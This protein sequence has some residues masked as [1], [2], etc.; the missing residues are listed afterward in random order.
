MFIASVFLLALCKIEDTDTWMHLSLGRLI[1]ELK[2]FP[3]HETLVYTSLDKP[4]SYSSWLFGLIYY[5]SYLA[6]GYYGVILLKAFTVSTAFYILLRDSLRPHRNYVVSVAVLTFV[7]FMARH[8]FVERP[9]T[10]MAVFLPFSIFSL[11]AF[12]YDNKKYIYVLPLIHMLWANSH[13]SV[14][15]MVVPF[16]AFLMGGIIQRYLS[17]KGI[18]SCAQYSSVSQL[19]VVLTIFAVSFA[20][21]LIS[22]YAISQYSFGSQFLA[23]S[24]FKQEI[25]ELRPPTWAMMKLPFIVTP[26][27]FLSFFFNRKRVSVFHLFLVAPF[28][29]LQFTAV[30]FVFLFGIVSGPVV[31]RNVS[32]FVAARP[33]GGLSQR[34]WIEVAA[35]ISVLAVCSLT[36]LNIGPFAARSK[37]FGFGVNYDMA[38]M[39]VPEK[40]LQYMDRRGIT[41]R[42]FNTFHYG[43]YINWR[44]FPKRTVFIDP[45]GYMEAEL[46]E[47]TGRA[48]GNP[49]VFGELANR[50][51]FESC[52]ISYPAVSKADVE[53]TGNQLL[54][55]NAG[56]A[57]VY[58]DDV[59]LVYLKKG[60]KYDSV[61]RQDEYRFVNPAGGTLGLKF[62]ITDPLMREG[63]IRELE[64]NIRETGSSK[65]YEY[66]GHIFGEMRRYDEAVALLKK[67]LDSR[68]ANRHSIYYE[69]A[70]AYYGLG[71][72]A[73]SIECCQKSLA[74]GEDANGL[75]LLSM[76]YIQRGDYARA[77]KHLERASALEPARQ[78][79]Y[80][81]LMDTYARLGRTDKLEK[82]RGAYEKARKQAQA[83]SHFNEGVNAYF[84]G[85]LEL[86]AAELEKA[87]EIDPNS[88]SAYSNLGYVFFD[89]GNYAEA[90]EC[91][92]KAL[93]LDRN[94]ANAHYGLALIYRNLGDNEEAKRHWQEYLRIEPSGYYTRRA[95][96]GLKGLK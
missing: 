9:D 86:A 6:G 62:V 7:V 59:S 71:R 27:V 14:V 29:V 2:G 45:R 58:W 37:A 51:G 33:W 43:G 83:E 61:V 72:T 32:S 64:R 96:E 73:E 35:T 87:I 93:A 16:L 17:E 26:I 20:A 47:K 75:Y 48:P 80:P 68:Y 24:W 95:E 21:T 52:L 31:A 94:Y 81:I 30:R 10:F 66:L 69:L 23:S 63:T 11:N 44:D 36:V 65:A 90:M 53:T 70:F 41:G 67:A 39:T 40:A 77:V 19:K 5:L 84:R 56:W 13:S 38:F 60:G 46:L 22:P 91:Q 85:S 42:M 57:L 76:A 15:L 1:W 55:Q 34:R 8:R 79:F 88:P 4:F 74:S 28:A 89:K 3:S 92:K 25:S 49:L 18:F 82:A 12:L 78:D 50:Y 54:F